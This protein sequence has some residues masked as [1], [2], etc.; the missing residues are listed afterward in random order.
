M[1][2]CFFVLAMLYR[3]WFSNN[4][5]RYL[6]GHRRNLPQLSCKLIRHQLSAKAVFIFDISVTS[7]FHTV[8][9]GRLWVSVCSVHSYQGLIPNNVHRNMRNDKQIQGPR[10][11]NTG[12]FSKSTQRR[13]LRT[14]HLM[15]K[16]G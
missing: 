8:L 6:Q 11:Q 5:Q 9:A 10:F 16:L 15:K 14:L 2:Y 4:I 13:D 1:P 12:V 7:L 3:N